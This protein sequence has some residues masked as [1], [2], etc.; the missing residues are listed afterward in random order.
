MTWSSRRHQ[1]WG[2][3]ASTPKTKDTLLVFDYQIASIVNYL[4]DVAREGLLGLGASLLL[5]GG[6]DGFRRNRFRGLA[7]GFLDDSFIG[8]R[9]WISHCDA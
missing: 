3:P 2:A 7:S 1:F 9:G 4:V 6:M 8:G 5:V